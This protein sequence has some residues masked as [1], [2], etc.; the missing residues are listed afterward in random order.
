[1][2]A[3]GRFALLVQIDDIAIST[4]WDSPAF[5][6][7][8]FWRLITMINAPP[9]A[10]DLKLKRLRKEEKERVQA[11]RETFAAMQVRRSLEPASSDTGGDKCS[12]VGKSQSGIHYDQSHY[13]YS[14]RYTYARPDAGVIRS[15]GGSRD[16]SQAAA[17]QS[18]AR[19]A[20]AQT[21]EAP[22]ARKPAEFK[23]PSLARVFGWFV[24]DG[25]IGRVPC[26]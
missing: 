8:I 15:R 19:A 16:G 21:A 13:L 1:V 5:L 11:E 23:V 3:H 24:L 10:T 18:S 7:V 22:V 25:E 6:R 26:T 20:S 4:D 9:R 17:R 14:H 2:C 12:I